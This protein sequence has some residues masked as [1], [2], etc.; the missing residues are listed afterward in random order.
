M[1]LKSLKKDYVSLKQA[2]HT[3]QALK[4]GKISHMIKNQIYGR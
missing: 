2:L 1:S 3:M 4:Y